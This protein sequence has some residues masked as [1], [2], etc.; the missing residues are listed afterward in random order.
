M[1]NI[2]YIVFT[3]FL[4][5]SGI[6]NAQQTEMDKRQLFT[7]AEQEYQIGR[8]DSAIDMLGREISTYSGTLKVSAY[9]LLALC[10]LAQDD[11]AAA[12]KY[13]DLLLKEDPYYSISINDPERLAELIRNKKEGKTTLVTASQQAETL[14]EVPVP[15]TLITEDMIKAIGA[16]DLRDVLAAYVPGITVVEG[17]QSNISMHGIY[18][19]TQEKILFMLNGHRLNSRST[20]AEAPDFRNSLDKIKQIEVLRG[21]ASSL[22]GNVALTAV[23]NI[24]T[25]SGSDVNGLY[26]SYGM[27]D[28]STIKGDVLF[29]KRSLDTDVLIWASIY[30]SQGETRPISSDDE[31]FMGAIPIDGSMRI[32]GFNHKPAYDIGLTLRWKKIKLM[33][34]QQYSK[35][36]IPYTSAALTPTIYDYDKY[37]LY[38]GIKPGNGR[39][40]T[41]GE[42][43]YSDSK[44]DFSWN[45]SLFIDAEEH[46]NYDVTGDTLT[47]EDSYLPIYNLEDE[48]IKD[49]M[50]IQS[51]GVYQIL[52]WKDYTYGGSV[53]GNYKYKLGN[54]SN[55]NILIGAQIE[56][57]KMYYNSFLLGDQFDRI[58]ITYSDR[59]RRIELGNE[60]NLSAFLQLKHYFTKKLIFNGGLR[61]DYK[62][63]Y[64]DKTLRAFSPRLSLIYTMNDVWSA[65][66]GYSRSFVDAPFFYRANKTNAYKGGENLNA[67]YINAIQVSTAASFTPLHLH[68]DCNVYFNKLNDLI[69]YDTDQRMYINAGKL[70][71]VGIENVL[72]Y[73]GQTI[74]ASCNMSYQHVLKAEHY[75]VEGHRVYDVPSFTSNLIVAGKL[76]SPKPGQ[77]AWLRGN[78]SFYSNQISPIG[79][80]NKG[81]GNIVSIPD[82]KVDARFIVHIGGVYNWNKLELSIQ[83]YNVLNKH[84]KQGGAHLLYDVPQQG[85]SF[86]AKIAY[87]IQ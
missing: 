13:V 47:A 32:E 84:Y 59:N 56:N 7:Q 69:F 5:L 31:D 28:N 82:N 6:A 12:N 38:N 10:Y 64:N 62:H 2:T 79:P 17:N 81:P 63:R 87:T 66:L 85:R 8:I 61:F 15:V 77:T 26:A 48:Y 46:T 18:S 41:R 51:T 29:G 1:R 78:M 44:N 22:Y 55:G 14:E 23:V 71:L 52:E 16:R 49:S 58:D 83:C 73:T 19:A 75:P 33:F 37:R 67:E 4:S 53:S 86:L 9:R 68:Y 76:F 20:N 36:V 42:L 34:N 57:Y 45:A 11:L 65:K 74:K 21:P 40:S 35:K 72:S 60:L 30:S 3:L 27:G 80:I 54:H 25:K 24:I 50:L 70:S 43:A 39:L